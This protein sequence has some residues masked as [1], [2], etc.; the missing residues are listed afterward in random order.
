MAG[1]HK[2]FISYHHTEDQ[3]YA[4]ALKAFWEPANTLIDRSL[5]EEIDSDNDDYILSQIR[6]KHLKDSTVTIVLIGQH[7]WSRKWV[8]W[9]I[10]S[11]LRPYGNRT[12]NGILGIVLPTGEHWPARILDNYAEADKFG[13]RTQTGYAKVVRWSAVA[14]P[15]ALERVLNSKIYDERKR[16]LSNWIQYAF[17]N[18]L[19]KEL[20]DNTR[21]RMKRN[22]SV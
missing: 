15:T 12:V 17:D 13:R 19:K 11:S 2:V 22:R 18:R 5:P 21:P 16:M 8:D 10:Y 6:T 20:I 7:T 9:E 3:R 4:N 14:P 1:S